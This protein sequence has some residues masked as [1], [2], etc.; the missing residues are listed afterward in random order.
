[1]ASYILQIKDLPPGKHYVILRDESYSIPGWG[2]DDTPDHANKI[3][4][5][6]YKDEKDWRGAIELYHQF[7]G[8]SG[9][10]KKPFK[11]AIIEIPTIGVSVHIGD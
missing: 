5:E 11:P 4:I 8:N 2:K 7:G 9:P 6:V 1:M 3:S 10:H